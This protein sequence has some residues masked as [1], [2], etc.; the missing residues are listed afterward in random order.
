MKTTPGV[1]RF[2]RIPESLRAFRRMVSLTAAK[3]NRMFDVSVAWVRLNYCSAFAEG[4]EPRTNCGYTLSLARFACINRQRMYFAALFISAP[5]VYSGK[6]F[7]NGTCKTRHLESVLLEQG[8][9]STFGS[10]TLKTSILFKNNMMDVRRNQR[11]LMTDSNRINDSAIR[12]CVLHVVNLQPLLGC[13]YLGFLLKQNLI[14]LTQSSTKDN[15]RHTLE[16]MY[17][18]FTL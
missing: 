17:P 14:V 12:F 4:D 1:K 2:H 8:L 7:S 10:L 5:P 13:T 15:A 18:F 3:T 6:Y 16:A 11:E 9:E